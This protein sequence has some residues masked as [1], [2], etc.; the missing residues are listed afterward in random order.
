MLSRRI[1]PGALVAMALTVSLTRDAVAQYYSDGCSSCGTAMPMAAAPAA[2]CTPV[3]PVLQTCYQ[4]VPVTTY[5]REK[6]TVEVPYYET[7]YEDREVTV[8]RPVTRQREVE[9]PTVSYQNVTEYQTVN[10][11]MGRW[12]TQYHPIA[13]AAPCQVDPRPGVIGWMNRTGYSMRTAFMPSYSTS[14]QYVPNMMVCNVPVTRQV[15]VQGTRRVTVSETQMVAERK[16]ERV[17]VQKLAY[18]KEEVT[19]MRPQTAY[20]TVPIGTSV[21]Y[22]PGY[23]TTTAY[24]P[25]VGGSAMA[26]GLPIIESTNSTRSA[27]APKPDPIGGG[28]RSADRAPFRADDP[29]TGSDSFKRETSPGPAIQGS[30]LQRTFPEDSSGGGSSADPEPFM[31]NFGT[32]LDRNQQPLASPAG[33]RKSEPTVTRSTGSSGWKATRSEYDRRLTSTTLSNPKVSLADSSVEKK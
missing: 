14:R 3:Q 27:L 18:R 17:A 19:V 26:F 28:S 10:R 21:A 1:L 15:A 8:M 12:V 13:R 24:A 9:V 7:A 2:Y 5:S 23:G 20:R 31:P 22:G 25:Y 30:S 16:T 11:D 32:S 29:R 4:T 33:A 6:Q